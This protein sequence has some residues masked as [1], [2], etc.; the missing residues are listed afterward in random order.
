[1]TRKECEEVLRRQGLL[2]KRPPLG[3]IR[4]FSPRSRSV[5]R[6]EFGSFNR[7][8]ERQ[9]TEEN[10]RCERAMAYTAGLKGVYPVGRP[11]R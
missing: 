9:D 7:R 4:I 2:G 1:M 10:D 8:H 3:G 5:M 6:Q 11:G